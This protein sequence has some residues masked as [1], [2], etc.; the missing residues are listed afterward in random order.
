MSSPYKECSRDDP[1]DCRLCGKPL[2]GDNSTGICYEC[3]RDVT[4]NEWKIAVDKVL[5]EEVEYISNLVIH[6][7]ALELEDYLMTILSLESMTTDQ[8]KERWS[9]IFS[10]K[11][12]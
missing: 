12:E 11:E 8:I 9:S 1:E 6:G 3:K 10:E 2:A 7:P 4:Q 5:N